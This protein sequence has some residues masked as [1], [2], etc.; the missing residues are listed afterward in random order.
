MARGFVSGLG[1]ALRALRRARRAADDARRPALESWAKDTRDTAKGLV[2]VRT[3]KLRG[4]IDYR[5]I[6]DA[7]A[8][9]G[10][11]GPSRS[12]AGYQEKG[13]SKMRAQPFMRPAFAAHR[14]DLSRRYRR[15]FRLR[16]RF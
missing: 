13:T 2:R 15:E 16:A 7:N 4:D 5:M 12:Y 1:D 6:N 8:N 9:V 14:N 11:Y 3:G 10:V